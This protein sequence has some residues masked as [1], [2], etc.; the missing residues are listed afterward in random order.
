MD[1]F[2]LPPEAQ[3]LSLPLDFG[4]SGVFIN[5]HNLKLEYNENGLKLI[6]RFRV[7]IRNANH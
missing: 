2:D 7:D 5:N 1:G 6:T 4:S 3:T